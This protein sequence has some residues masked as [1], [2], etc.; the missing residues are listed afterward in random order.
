MKIVEAIIDQ[1][2]SVLVGT[3]L[4]IAI[5]ILTGSVIPVQRSPAITK[6]VILVAV[7]YPGA[8]PTEVEEQI[9]R[10]IEDELRT[11]SDVD[12]IASTSMRG[13]SITQIIFLDD[14]D[15]DVARGEVQDLVEQVQRELPLAREVQPQVRK[16]DFEN[17]PLMLVNISP[18]ADFDQRA[19]K[20]LAEEVQEDL[21]T[22]PGVSNTQLF[23]G[24]EREIHV[25]VDVSLAS[26]YGLSLSDFRQA[27]SAFHA[28]LP[29]G[30]LNTGQFDF[31][32]RSETRFRDVE[33]IRQ[34]VI[35][36]QEGRVIH[37]GDVAQ[38]VD[39]YQRLANVSHLDAKDCATII[40]NKEADINT[41][42][43]ARNV[44]ERVDSLQQQ[45][46]FVSFSITRD[47]SEEISLMFRVLGSSFLFGAML[48]LIILSW[49]MGLR[50][51]I[52]VL[53]AIPLSCAMGLN[54]L[55]LFEIPLSNMAIFSYI[56]VLGMVVDGAIIVTE[57][58]HRHVERGEDPRLAAKSGIREVGMPVIMADLTT[59]AA[60]LPMLLVPG[61]M[62]DFMSVMPKVVAMSL[63]G[64]VLVDHFLIPALAA[65]WY[66]RRVSANHDH[67][68]P[69]TGNDLFSNA[70]NYLGWHQKVY[71]IILRWALGNRWAIVTCAVLG[72]TWAVLMLGQIGFT[73]FP[74]S[75]RGQFQVKIELPLGTSIH[76][77]VAAAKAISEPL[78]QLKKDPRGELVHYVSAIGSSEGFASRLEN[79][80]TLGPEF[81]T[82]MVQLQSPLDRQRHENEI[83]S[84]LRR[85]F[86]N[87]VT[88][89]PGLTYTIDQVEEGPPGGAD[90]AVRFTGKDLP[91]LGK[92]ARQAADQLKDLPGT[93]D[94]KVDYRDENPEIIVEPDPTVVGLYDFTE[95]QLSQAIQTAIHGDT[96]IELNLGDD[97]VTLRLQAADEYQ[98]SQGDLKRLMLTSP[99]GKRA[100]V[101]ELASLRRSTGL[102]AVNRYNHSRATVTQCDVTKATIKPNDVFAVLRANILPQLGF[103]PVQGN[104]MAFLG[105]AGSEV[106]GIRATF[107]GE[108]EEQ[109]KNFRY[110]LYCMIIAVF[111]IFFIL[112]LQFKSFRQTAL[113]LMTVPLSFIGVVA[114]M[115]VCSFPFS[116]ASFI[117]LVA[118]T[119]V[120]VNDAIVM[121]DFIN[122]SRAKGLQLPNAIIDASMNRLRPVILTT[123]TTIGGLAPLFFNWSGGAEFWQPLTGA[124]I[125]GLMV[126]SVLTL[127][128]VPVGYSLMYQNKS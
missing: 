56:L 42:K 125:F 82:V 52:L 99:T 44:K 19:L 40:V 114:G 27:L 48:V 38:V 108:N 81:G 29:G 33:D 28:E 119:G 60:Y 70:Q 94:V 4:V 43:T 37:I 50:T 90:V 55:Y 15:P 11:L 110:L 45:Y 1:P 80:P 105:K 109:Q 23:G 66:Q 22:V 87:Q 31:R 68:Q 103:E 126:A 96:S 13:S 41:L 46:P 76:Q 83:I 34:A 98:R 12:S 127:I 100:T 16:I 24:R 2:R 104:P 128:V 62:G 61:I 9:T 116:L 107:T 93:I 58:I 89:F 86:D 92:V 75:D 18:P 3:A 14:V 8:Q 69:N 17:T 111:L 115:W 123:V 25:N 51:S 78:N 122:Q 36:Q 21:E 101:G 10:Q 71:S 91:Q 35:A 54:F 74:E 84:D 106:E 39:T 124:I 72:L 118:L 53:I 20:L 67:G 64:S 5:A 30:A 117:G 85:Q 7:P 88:Q 121:V 6:A 32:I 77:T 73:F 95:T 47:T 112:V 65:R 79:D 63:F 59:I 120:V 49:T 113:V 97:D 57:N 26:E 102:Y